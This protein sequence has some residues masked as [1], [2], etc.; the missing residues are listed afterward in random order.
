[1]RKNILL[2]LT[3]CINHNN[4][5]VSFNFEHLGRKKELCSIL[6]ESINLTEAKNELQ[7]HHLDFLNRISSLNII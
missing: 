4:P 3:E 6:C 5:S 1:M 2:Y 7:Q